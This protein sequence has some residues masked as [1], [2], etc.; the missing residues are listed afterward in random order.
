MKN[1]MTSKRNISINVP[2][3]TR[4]E[5]EGALEL[6]IQ[7]NEIKTLNLRI[8]EPPRYFEKFLEGRSY[9]DVPDMVARICGICPVAYQMSAVQALENAF[10]QTPSAW[11][12]NMRRLLYCGEWIQSHSLHIH[13]LAA[14]DFIGFNNALE[15]SQHHPEIVQRGLR[16]QSLGNDI[17]AFLGGRSVHP[18]GVLP[19]GF[20]KSP[21]TD[22]AVILLNKL[23]AAEQDCFDLIDWACQLDLPQEPQAF[24]SVSLRNNENYP[25]LNGDLVS[26][27]GLHIHIDDYEKHF[28]EFHAPHSTALHSLLDGQAYLVGPLARMNLNYELINDDVRRI[29]ERNN[30]T[31]PSRNIFHSIIARAVELA[32]AMTDAIAIL[33][34]Y[35]F[36]EKPF[37][38]LTPRVST[39]IGCTEAP[40]GLLW[41]K[42]K[43]DEAGNICYAN[44]IPPTS[45]NQAQI[46][47]DLR[48]SILN[49][50]LDKSDDT[51]KQYSETIIRNYDPCISCATHFLQLKINRQ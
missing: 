10:D 51:L 7:N 29:L 2:V 21:S 34:N 3:L 38:Q 39:G 12:Q 24:I 1:N 8:F 45:Q 37:E 23:K 44:I 25:M 27:N 5:G 19:G 18:V 35:T 17:I 22:A 46:E 13:L 15:M 48:E 32:G 4:V 26:S 14:P 43:T 28:K 50:G 20:Y 30:I 40:R 42:Y 11:I 47:K 33:N 49:Y 31:F 36:C 16:L 9:L 41:H 6:D